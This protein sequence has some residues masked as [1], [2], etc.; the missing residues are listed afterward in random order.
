M[1]INLIGNLASKT[2]MATKKKRRKIGIIIV[3]MSRATMI[4]SAM[5][6]L[7]LTIT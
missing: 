4:G 3:L 6:I 1:K 2:V 5:P 7:M